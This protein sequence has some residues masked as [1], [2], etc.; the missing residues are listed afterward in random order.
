MLQYMLLYNDYL[1]NGCR[2]YL[3][4]AWYMARIGFSVSCISI[5]VKGFSVI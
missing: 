2:F 3:S 1:V 4:G 5:T